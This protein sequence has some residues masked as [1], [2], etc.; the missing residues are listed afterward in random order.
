M[1]KA[2]APTVPVSFTR[3]LYKQSH[4]DFAIMTGFQD[5]GPVAFP[6]ITY[7]LRANTNR[8]LALLGNCL[9]S[10]CGLLRRVRCGGLSVRA[11]Q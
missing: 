5:E 9:G 1:S 3:E 11:G 8:R 4:C 6:W 2:G 10:G 7:P